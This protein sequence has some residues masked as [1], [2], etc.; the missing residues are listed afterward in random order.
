[1]A[2]TKV[3]TDVIDMSGNAGGLTWVKG[4]TAQRE[5]APS[6][7]VG[8]LRENTETKR[9][10]IYT[11]QTGTAEWRNLKESTA[12]NNSDSEYL[13]VAGG[14]GGGSFN[15]GGGGGAGGLKTNFGGTKI[16]L[17]AGTAYTITVGT[18]GAGKSASAAGG[19]GANSIFSGS[20]ITTIES[21]GGGGGATGAFGGGSI[22]PAGNGG[23]GGGSGWDQ[24]NQ[25][26][27]VSGEGFAGGTG[28]G[29]GGTYSGG[30]GG[31]AS[32]AGSTNGT[33]YGGDGISNSIT[34]SAID[35]AGGGGGGSDSSGSP[36]GAG[37]GG[38]G[39]IGAGTSAVNG[40]TNKGGGGG[41]GHPASLPSG[42]GGSG[43]VILRYPNVFTATYTA[44]TGGTADTEVTVGTDKYIKI[45]AGTGTV[46]FSAPPN[47]G[48]PSSPTEGLLRDNTTTGALEFYDGSLWQQISGTL[49]SD[50]PP[51]DNFNTVIWTSTGGNTDI[52]ITGVGFKPDFVWAKSRT[53]AYNHTLYDSV[54]EAG[55]NHWLASDLSNSES[56]LAA[57]AA[58]YGYLGSFDNN[59]F[60]G[61]AGTSD[62]SYFNYNTNK[63]YVGWNWKAGGAKVPNN[64]GDITTQVSVNQAAGF[65]IVEYT[66]TGNGASKIGHGITAGAPDLIICKNASQSGYSWAVYSSA[67]PSVTNNL[68]LDFTGFINQYQDRFSAVTSTTFTAGSNYP[69]VNG[70]NDDM[71]AYCW[72]SVPGYSKIGSYTWTA[73]NYTAGPMVANLGFTPRFVMIK[74]TTVT[75]NWYIFDNMRGQTGTYVYQVPLAPDLPD[76]E[77]TTAQNV[78]YQSIQFNSNGFS[79]MVW[80]ASGYTTGSTGLNEQNQTYLYFAIA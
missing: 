70:N 25:G 26:S 44:G 64:E 50:N 58:L 20:D 9:T 76:A 31:G 78:G 71:I 34:G 52:S 1:M 67:L 7:G 79:A 16:T 59:G 66:G 35:Y 10:E 63:N 62:N 18:P 47:S 28:S 39:A 24:T 42:D 19:N 5:A 33:G 60:T 46:A 45:T 3:T 65:S 51:S 54:R 13:V 27:E 6:T 14:G 21:T 75:S 37:G 72:K 22:N 53:D 56:S 29:N 57:S 61:K 8:N 11:D 68:F 43:V 55:T 69:E 48:R 32:E 30:G 40:S 77:Q 17:S 2:T 36:G 73:T 38:T 49:V 4:T 15:N 80:N 12:R 74:G 41:G 23:S